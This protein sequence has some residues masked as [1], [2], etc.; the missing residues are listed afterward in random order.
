MIETAYFSQNLSNRRQERVDADDD[1]EG[2]EATGRPVR[3]KVAIVLG[4]G[5]TGKEGT[6]TVEVTQVIGHRP[7][8]VKGGDEAGEVDAYL[9]VRKEFLVHL[10][11]P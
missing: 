10:G 2:A 4:E 9:P 11:I 6:V 3:L 5:A 8:D 1:G 7:D